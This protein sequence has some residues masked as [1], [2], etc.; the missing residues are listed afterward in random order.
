MD[1]MLVHYRVTPR[2]FTG[3]QYTLGG[4]RHCA[5]EVSCRR[6]QHNGQQPGVKPGLL[7]LET[8]MLIRTL[9]FITLDQAFFLRSRKVWP[10]TGPGLMMQ[11]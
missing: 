6:T 4:E 7:D 2:V 3:T 5:S 1:E 11:D 9:H 10:I 8:S